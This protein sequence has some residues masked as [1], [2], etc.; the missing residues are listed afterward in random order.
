VTSGAGDPPE[1]RASWIELFFDL[2]LVA[3]VAAL[4]AQLHE[5]RSVTA[6]AV[7][8]GLFVPV[9][10]A[11]WGFTW[12][13]AAFNADDPVNRIGLLVGMAG[14]A[15]MVV[16]IPGATHGHSDT[17]VIAYA[18]LC[19]ILAALYARAWVAVPPARPLSARYLAGY[20]LGALTWLASLALDE[21]VRP[22]AWALAMV[23][24][25]SFPVWA[26]ASLEFRSSDP[27]HIAERYGLF[28]LIVLGESVAAAVAGLDTGSSGTAVMVALFGLA[29]AAAV[30]WLYFDRWQG[31]PAGRVRSGAVWAQGHFF[32]FAGI[33]AAAVGVEHAVE[34]AAHS[35]ALEAADRLP[36]GA[37][38]AAYLLAMATI[39]AATRR[40]DAIVA[41][42]AG[43]AAVVVALALSGI[44]SPL[45]FIA[46]VAVAMVGECAIDL[47]ASPPT[48]PARPLLPHELRVRRQR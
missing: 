26:A 29:I 13:S 18:V 37:G 3:A 34:A 31:M 43:A 24:L 10:W 48:R 32:V 20:V 15:G 46:L 1:R 12:Y 44:A 7:F 39:R 25:M 27:T 35:E 40:A 33:A 23:L 2:V 8:A 4:A 30:W 42:R 28:T 9:W 16:G 6:L 38:L 41:L 21:G 45:W 47:G 17:F 19:A 5:D 11:W 36:L 14:V 22:I